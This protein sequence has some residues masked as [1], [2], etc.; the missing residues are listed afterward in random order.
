MRKQRIAPVLLSFINLDVFKISMCRKVDKKRG[1][2]LPNHSIKLFS[3]FASWTD[4]YYCI[5]S[6]LSFL[7]SSS[8]WV[9]G[10]EIC[11]LTFLTN[12]LTARVQ[13][14]LKDLYQRWWDYWHFLLNGQK[15][16][17]LWI[18]NCSYSHAAMKAWIF[19]F[20]KCWL[21]KGHSTVFTLQVWFICNT[22]YY[23]AC[24]SE[25]TFLKSDKITLY[26][27][28]ISVFWRFDPYLRLKLHIW[29]LLLWLF[30]ANQLG[31]AIL[32][33]YISPLK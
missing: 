17:F 15:C 19:Y 18:R 2:L 25:K 8:Q 31:G 20:C 29:A 5:N 32:N 16:V 1:K 27:V 14:E 11:F 12:H 23:S 21:K 7:K 6:S 24:G 3:V 9:T 4:F 22:V 26:D 10:C 30:E 13:I 33:C 28:M